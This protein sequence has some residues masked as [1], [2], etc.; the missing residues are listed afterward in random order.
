MCQGGL[1]LVI[2]T[3]CI[4]TVLKEQWG[5]I[6]THG[7]R[8]TRQKLLVHVSVKEY[9]DIKDRYHVLIGKY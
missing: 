2:L 4:C 1:I 7:V 6:S 5:E 9:S 8:G 3:P